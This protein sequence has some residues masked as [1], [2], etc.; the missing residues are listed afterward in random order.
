MAERGRRSL[1]YTFPC[2][3]KL[4]TERAVDWALTVANKQET[5][6]GVLLAALVE[7]CFWLMA[8]QNA[9][10]VDRKC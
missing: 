4:S 6:L 10:G 2:G 7:R 1:L 5:K 9:A 8:R 3:V